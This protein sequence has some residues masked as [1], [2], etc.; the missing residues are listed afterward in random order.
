M[1][2]P[3]ASEF[4]LFQ[5]LANPNKTDFSRRVA[6]PNPFQRAVQSQFK[7]KSTVSRHSRNSGRRSRSR[8]SSSSSR[9]SRSSS[10]SRHSRR[11]SRSSVSSKGSRRSGGGGALGFSPSFPTHHESDKDSAEEVT[12]EKQGYLLELTKFKQ[13][14]I[15]LT[16]A[17][18]MDDSLGDIQFEYERIKSN[19][20]TVNNVALIRDTL[21]FVFQGIEMANHKWGPILQLDGWADSLMQDR[22]RYDHVLE[23]LYKKHWRLGSHVSP[24]AEF[25]WL[26][27]SSMVKHH[28]KMKASGGANPSPSASGGGGGGSKFNLSSML[29]ILGNVGGL[30]GGGGGMAAMMGGARPAG[31]PGA[32]RPPVV[33]SAPPTPVQHPNHP[34]APPMRP[35]MR[36]PSSSSVVGK[37]A[38]MPR[39]DFAPGL[40][41][42]NQHHQPPP[43]HH[44]PPP[45]HHHSAPPAAAPDMRSQEEIRALRAQLE[46]ERRQMHHMQSVMMNMRDEIRVNKQTQEQMERVVRNQSHAPPPLV[47]KPA[48]PAL[49]QQPPAPRAA[50]KPVVMQAEPKVVSDDSESGSA[51]DAPDS[52]D[53]EDDKQVSI[54]GGMKRGGRRG[55]ATGARKAVA[56][57]KLDL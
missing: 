19:L 31:P 20:A 21:G 3:S 30:M 15:E 22:Q 4:A 8:S 14:G 51:P 54:V 47:V 50:S 38:P 42:P 18:T 28:L 49:P 40:H 44:Q 36:P 55:A 57:L 13:Q 29:G 32:M 1:P 27:G 53:T 34:N 12:L 39:A 37:D 46:D 56:A 26:I 24:E 52:D 10:R 45:S 17:Y 9:R 11:S 5:K 7:A 48:T 2:P 25:G 41:Q 6:V 35:V 33:H 16:R 43:P 23:R